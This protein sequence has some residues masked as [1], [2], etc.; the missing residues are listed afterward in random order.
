M[1]IMHTCIYVVQIGCAHQ[2]TCGTNEV[3]AYWLRLRNLCTI[4]LKFEFHRPINNLYYIAFVAHFLSLTH[5][6]NN[7]LD[8]KIIK[9]RKCYYNRTLREGGEL[10]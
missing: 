5:T 6:I 9:Q 10:Y 8:A 1:Y 4:G 7:M 2:C 3:L